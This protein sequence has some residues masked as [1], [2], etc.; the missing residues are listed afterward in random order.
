[1][2]IGGG[3][4]IKYSSPEE[5]IFHLKALDY[6]AA[7][8]PV[9]TDSSPEVRRAYREAAERNGVVIGEVG[10]WKNPLAPDEAE[11]KAAFDACVAGMALA[12]EMGARCAVNISG[13]RGARWDGYDEDNY[14]A[15]TY[16]L[17]IDQVRAVVDAVKPKKAVY[18]LEPMPWMHPWS[19]DD[20]LQML[21]DVDRPGFGVHLDFA[22]MI[23]SIERYHNRNAFVK[24]CFD[25][26]GPHIASIHAKDVALREDKL[27]CTIQ[28]GMP[29]TGGIDFAQ[30][31]RLADK[32]PGETTLF[33][34]HISS[35][36]DYQKAVAYLR[37]IADKEGITIPSLR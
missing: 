19:P 12:E 32:L 25:K 21:R 9:G 30:V 3:V 26:L 18:S 37:G 33:V 22:N 31:L 28:E 13:S 1:M 4:E 20:Y 36:N 6:S 2:R 15:D 16:A 5:W 14:S 29:G 10:V 27:P 11:R 8:C 24:E 34:E 23:N 17:I 35:Y 7:I